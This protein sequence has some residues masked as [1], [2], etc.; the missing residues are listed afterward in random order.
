M[1]FIIGLVLMPFAIW[2][3]VSAL[4]EENIYDDEIALITFI[5]VVVGAL[6]IFGWPLSILIYLTYK[7]TRFKVSRRDK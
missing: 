6:T 1:Y 7:L 4:C 3:T 2:L 5:S